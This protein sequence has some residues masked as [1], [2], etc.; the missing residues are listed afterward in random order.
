M[1][2]IS[3]GIRRGRC[4]DLCSLNCYIEGRKIHLVIR[5]QEKSISSHSFCF[6]IL[7]AFFH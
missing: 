6:C 2:W 1:Q 3:L 4:S 5:K 7:C